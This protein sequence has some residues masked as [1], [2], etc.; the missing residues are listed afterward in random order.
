MIE[1]A[2]SYASESVF[3]ELGDI[4]MWEGRGSFDVV[5]SNASLQWVPDHPAVMGRWAHALRPGGQL[6]IQVPSNAD[7]PANA[8][9]DEVAHEFLADPPTDAVARNVL[10]PEAYAELLYGLGFE[11]QNVRLQV[12][13]HHLSLVAQV[14]EW[15][16]GTSLT[17][18]KEPLGQARW[19]E[20][21]DVYRER[22]VSRLGERS[23][24]LYAFKRILMWAR[25]S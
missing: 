4:G 2:G 21:V 19:D 24:Y 15:M 14:V 23:P 17:R 13:V 8:L 5:F 10:A 6:A 16:K 20:F 9:A 3:F 7:H 22:L 25:L 1:S 18:F 11:E 12:Y